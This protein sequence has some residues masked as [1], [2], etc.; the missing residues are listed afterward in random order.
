MNEVITKLYE[1]EETAG[2]IL[3]DAGRYKEQLQQQMAM[4]QKA[5][6]KEMEADLQHR[7][8]NTKIQLDAQAQQEIERKQREFQQQIEVLNEN[9][10]N[11][12]E[13]LAEGIF[14]KITEV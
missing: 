2:Q 11:H 5:Y 7:L 12:L 8:E 6:A 9:Y 14:L 13:E 3:K 10:D 1:I 4:E